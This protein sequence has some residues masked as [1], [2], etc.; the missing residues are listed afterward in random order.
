VP[1]YVLVI[2]DD[3]T[4][5]PP[6]ELIAKAQVAV[7]RVRPAGVEVRVVGPTIVEVTVAMTIKVSPDFETA[8]VQSAV[9]SQIINYVN[10]LKMGETLYLSSLSQEALKVEGVIAVRPN[11]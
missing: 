8:D 9:R 2:M 1:G 7:D 10:S 4:G 5:N 11:S 6:G 3:G